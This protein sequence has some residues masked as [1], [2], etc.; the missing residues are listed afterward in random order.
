M[1]RLNMLV[2]FFLAC[3]LKTNAQA[4]YHSTLRPQIHFSPQTGWMNDP[5]GLIY[6]RNEYHMFF[7]F[8][9]DSTVW[10]PMHWGHAISKDLVHWKQAPIALYPDSLGYIFSGSAVVDARN[11]GSFADDG[12]TALIAVFTQHDP[13][14][15]KSGSLYFQ[16]QSIAYSLDGGKN[17]TKYQANPVLKS[18]ALKDFR[19]PKVTWYPD[20]NKWIMTLTAG[21][22]IQFYSSKDLKTWIKESEFGAGLVR[23]GC[24]WECPD[25]VSFEVGGKTIWLLITSINPGGPQGGSGTQYFTGSFDGHSFTTFDT[26]TRWADYGSDNYA[27]VSFSNT[28]DE[29]IFLGWMSNWLYATRVP[30]LQWRSAMTLPRTMGLK[31]LDGSYFLSMKHVAALEKMV[32]KSKTYKQI[33]G[34]GQLHYNAPAR[35]EISMPSLHSFSLVFSN[36]AGQQV[37]AG[38]DQEKNAFFIDRSRAGKSDFNAGFAGIHYAP[39][40]TRA[41]NSTI[42][43]ILDNSSLEM[44]ADDGLTNMT[45]IFFPGQPY[46]ILKQVSTGKAVEDI[47]VSELSSIWPIK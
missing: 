19:D 25:L 28:G 29:K 18:P 26:A 14:G 32:I 41:G 40:L 9:P 44:F 12:K 43:L 4:I 6:F 3:L 8:Y 15:E 2:I 45:D 5:N 38:Y 16:N 27:G 23:P 11:T 22:R 47:R 37:S 33:P 39:R 17:W 35:F 31:K 7:Q 1:S 24:V 30:A 21:D 20:Q 42:I 46:D 36:A 34:S 13:K 10:G